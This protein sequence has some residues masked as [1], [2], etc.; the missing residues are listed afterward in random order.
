MAV[1]AAVV[2]TSLVTAG[3]ASAATPPPATSILA[4]G[5]HGHHHWHHHWHH[6]NID[7]DEFDFLTRASSEGI[8]NEY[9]DG[10]GYGHSGSMLLCPNPPGPGVSRW[11]CTRESAPGSVY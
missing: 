8:L 1:T 3:I 5:Y 2:T 10:W 4:S 11:T 7:G 9:F 6:N